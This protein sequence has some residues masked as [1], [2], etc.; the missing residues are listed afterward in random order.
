VE[1][2]RLAS[3][4]RGDVYT[5]S[6]EEENP[7]FSKDEV[8]VYT[9]NTKLKLTPRTPGGAEAYREETPWE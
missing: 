9:P 2:R 8:S 5:G 7:L 4:Q 6:W 3:L 1:T